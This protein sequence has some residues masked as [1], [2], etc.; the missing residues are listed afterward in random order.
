MKF[1]VGDRV[2][3]IIRTKRSLWST[4]GQS[5]EGMYGT[6]S[7]INTGEVGGYTTCRVNFDPPELS[8][9]LL[10]WEEDLQHIRPEWEI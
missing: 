10:F 5:L 9:H 1:K 8:R 4:Y 3:F 2:R 6:I 7:E